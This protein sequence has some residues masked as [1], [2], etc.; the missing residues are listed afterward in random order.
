MIQEERKPS[1]HLVLPVTRMR[2]WW[3]LDLMVGRHDSVGEARFGGREARF[4]HQRSATALE[5]HLAI[6]VELVWGRKGCVK[7]S[8]L[9]LADDRR[10]AC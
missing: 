6:V 5:G 7:A 3:K 1:C 9:V 4:K 2:R 8:V 10:G